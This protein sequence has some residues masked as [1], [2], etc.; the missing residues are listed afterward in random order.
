MVLPTA[1][2]FRL[3]EC[4][5]DSLNSRGS[6]SPRLLRHGSAAAARN[7][8]ALH[9]FSYARPKWNTERLI[10]YQYQLLVN[11]CDCTHVQYQNPCEWSARPSPFATVDRLPK[12]RDDRSPTTNA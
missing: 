10:S 11:G 4:I 8:Q 3:V 9:L 2:F 1:D 6:T 5:P 12:P 7:A